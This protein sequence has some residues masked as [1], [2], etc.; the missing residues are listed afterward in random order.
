MDGGGLKLDGRNNVSGI[1]KLGAHFGR[2]FTI[3]LDGLKD[4]H[5][6]V[7]LYESELS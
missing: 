6:M 3:N 4:K 7:F 5:W 2:S 1:K